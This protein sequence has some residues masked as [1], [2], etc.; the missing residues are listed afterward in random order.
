LANRLGWVLL[1]ILVTALLVAGCARPAEQ[2]YQ[3]YIFGTLLDI[4]LYGV[5][6]PQ[7]DAAVAALSERFQ[8]MHR[9]WH[10]WKPGELTDLNTAIRE[11]RPFKIDA[12]LAALLREGQRL[13]KLSGGLFDPAIGRLVG[14]WGF[15]ADEKPN[16]PPPDKAKIAELVAARPMMADLDIA[17]DGTVA[18]RNKYVQIDTGGFAK[19]AALDWAAADLKTRGIANA[20]LNAG[21]GIAVIGRHGER[22]WKVA[23]RNPSDWGIIASLDLGPDEALHT[24]GNYHRY[25]E[26]EGVHYSHILDPRTGMPVDRIVSASTIHHS[27]IM[28]DAAGK[29]LI[30]AG[31]Q[32]WPEAARAMGL[33]EVLL[34][35]DKG[36]IHTTP[37]MAKRIKLESDAARI[38]EVVDPLAR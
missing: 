5:D 2:K 21:G 28:A 16:G 32:H 13:E 11:G 3:L 19:G 38:V 27:G 30:V 17:A 35:D 1:P 29:A 25:L 6:K 9:D 36:G 20:I 37:K 10:P 8:R 26:Y 18:S 14:L 31:P 4:T 33:D 24:S 23:I 34:V 15:H 22:P 12:E 7:A